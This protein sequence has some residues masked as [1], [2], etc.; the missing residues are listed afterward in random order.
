L[1]EYCGSDYLYKI[2]VCF[3]SQI[4]ILRRYI[5]NI[6]IVFLIFWTVPYMNFAMWNWHCQ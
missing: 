6:T 2:N 4:L 1:C 3:L 5:E